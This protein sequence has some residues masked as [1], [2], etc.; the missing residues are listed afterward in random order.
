M[1]ADAASVP[2]ADDDDDEELLDSG[3]LADEGPQFASDASPDADSLLASLLGELQAQRR[4][5]LSVLVGPDHEALVS[6]TH[7]KAEHDRHLFAAA[8]LEAFR[9]PSRQLIATQ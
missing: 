1:R 2:R 9:V 3:V 8:L 7:V 4:T 6:N 5:S